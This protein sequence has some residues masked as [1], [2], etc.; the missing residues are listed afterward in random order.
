[1]RRERG[2][3]LIE[4]MISTALVLVIMGSLYMMII[5]YRNLSHSE[6][7]R[8][9]LQQ[10]SRFLLSS[11]AA[12]LKNA[13][14]VLTLA[15]TGG[16]LAGTAAFNGI[17]PINNTAYPDGVILAS[18]DPD[19][20]A[21]L[22][23]P[24]DP[25]SDGNT[26]NVD[27]ISVATGA[28]PWALDDFGVIVGP[29]GYYVFRVASVTG[30]SIV[31]RTESVYHS[32]L[33]A[34]ANYTDPE[35]VKGDSVSYPQ[36][37]PV[38]RLTSFG[39]YLVQQVWDGTLGRSRRDLIRVVDCH[40]VADV[41]AA[42]A[43]VDRYVIADNMWDIQLVYRTYPDFPDVTT[44]RVYFE[45]G[46]SLTHDDLLADIRAKVL[47]EVELNLI[48]LTSEFSGLGE[49]THTVSDIGDHAG[50]TLP[51]GKYMYRQ[52]RLTIEPR[53]FNIKL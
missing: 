46:S 47:K 31:K 42:G 37:A 22:F 52:Y 43:A 27:D 51:T 1:M 26:I 39:I 34:T 12:D 53:N 16:Y 4:S 10:E 17:Y 19:A 35:T 25:S 29:N 49:V 23:A 21:K 45:I 44:K 41:L 32:G 8:V 36:N 13:G 3:T 20:A 30:N 14:S 7:S 15:H 40:G 5:F 33:L 48:G 18:G 38:I 2:F 11:L 9:R 50:T 6:Q 28:D 24:Y